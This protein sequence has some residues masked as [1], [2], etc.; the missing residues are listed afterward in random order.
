MGGSPIAPLKVCKQ[1]SIQVQQIM[2][3]FLVSFLLYFG[4]LEP[5]QNC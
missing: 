4:L 1:L 2:Y 5:L 3:Y